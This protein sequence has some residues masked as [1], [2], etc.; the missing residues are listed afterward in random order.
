MIAEMSSWLAKNRG[1]ACD[2]RRHFVIIHQEIGWR[3]FSLDLL[4]TYEI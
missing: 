1:V 3:N 2:H 4:W